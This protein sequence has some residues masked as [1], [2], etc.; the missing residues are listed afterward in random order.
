MILA[1]AYLLGIR[2][3]SFVAFAF[4][5]NA[6]FL[7]AS[8]LLLYRIFSRNFTRDLALVSCFVVLLTGPVTWGYF[9][10][11]EIGLTILVF[12]LTVDLLDRELAATR[13]RWS[14]FLLGALVL[15]RPEAMTYSLI[16]S[17]F[18]LTVKRKELR[19][20]SSLLLLI[21]V[22]VAIVVF[23]LNKT[24]T[25]HFYPNSSRAKSPFFTP[26]FSPLF[27]LQHSV[28]F[29]TFAIKGLLQGTVGDNPLAPLNRIDS[30]AFFPPLTLFFYLL[31]CAPALASEWKD[32]RFGTHTF[33]NLWFVL[34]L[35][36]VAVLSG[37][38]HHHFRYLLPFLFVYAAY[39]PAGILTLSNA[40]SGSPNIRN[41]I[42]YGFLAFLF[43]FQS[44]TTA[45]F[46]LQFGQESYNFLAFKDVSLW[47]RRHLEPNDRILAMDVG[48]VAYY[49]ERPILDFYG[50][51]SNEMTPSTYFFADVAGSKYEAMERMTSKRQPK[52]FFVHRVRF[53]EKGDEDHLSPFR[54][55]R[56]YT[57]RIN[58]P[59]FRSIGLDLSLYK[60]NWDSTI[61]ADQPHSP[62]VLDSIR[63]Q[64][65][66][67]SLDVADLDSHSEH[68]YEFLPVVT[69]VFPANR[70][71][72]ASY[73]SGDTVRDGAWGIDGRE[74]FNISIPGRGPVLMVMRTVF[75][76]PPIE[77]TVNGRK[78]GEFAVPTDGKHWSELAVILPAAL[79]RVGANTVEASGRYM[80]AYYWFYQQL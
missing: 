77:V 34:G 52:Y 71:L 44:L 49:S 19:R 54:Q 25:G 45:N 46:L 62:Q 50:L 15:T 35:I 7:A 17:G 8:I 68:Q 21:P 9:S 63:E 74:R 5:L 4:I 18:M 51:V 79:F 38:G 30:Y 72:E 33:L 64:A 59:S 70:V 53:D 76:Q 22:A 37:S 42:Y 20:T 27:I 28:N 43:F 47:A 57:S 55:K 40:L 3:D 1:P 31:G 67:D 66:V 32:R 39:I 14:P 61:L 60:L 80:S 36:L 13:L 56:I 73:E 23:L 16:V 10:G 58:N 69:G 29:L 78:A 26:Y 11:M 12:L 48:M 6:V 2:G 41:G 24:L 75:I 65:L